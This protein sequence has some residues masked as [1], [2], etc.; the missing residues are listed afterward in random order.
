[1]IIGRIMMII[2]LVFSIPVNVSPCRNSI[3]AMLRKQK[4]T[5]PIYF[6]GLTICILEI[7]LGVA[8]AVPDIII[9]F[10]FLG[11]ICPML[12]AVVFPG[13]IYVRL[14]EEVT[15]FKKVIFSVGVVLMA[16]IG[17]ATVIVTLLQIFGLI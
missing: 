16:L 6:Y 4:D 17:I 8:I 12:L 1:M 10:N 3:L 15:T 9:V 14:H 2:A 7:T 13:M 5:K 11:G